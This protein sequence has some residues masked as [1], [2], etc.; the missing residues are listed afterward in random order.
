[1]QVLLDR[2]NGISQ[3][4]YDQAKPHEYAA[5]QIEQATEKIEFVCNEDGKILPIAANIR[6]GLLKL[7]VSVR[8]DQFADRSLLDGLPGLRPSARGRRSRS[9]VAAIHRAITLP[10]RASS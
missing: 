4:V 6:I 2:D 5:R 1:M 10:L 9:S 7:G 3:H 8:Y